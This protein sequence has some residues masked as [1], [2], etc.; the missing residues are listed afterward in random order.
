LFKATLTKGAGAL[1][2]LSPGYG[3]FRS[4]ADYQMTWLRKFSSTESALLVLPFIVVRQ[5]PGLCMR[6][7]PIATLASPVPVMGPLSAGHA[8]CGFEWW[9]RRR[10][11][12]TLACWKI[13]R[14]LT[15]TGQTKLKMKFRHVACPTYMLVALLLGVNSSVGQ[16][17]WTEAPGRLDVRHLFRSFR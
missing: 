10:N 11:F 7:L 5:H 14:P 2:A 12:P 9:S 8:R 16:S 13:F 4:V 17:V 3:R 15:L 1:I 6:V